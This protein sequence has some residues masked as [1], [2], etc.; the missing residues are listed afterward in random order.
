MGTVSNISKELILEIDQAMYE[1]TSILLHTSGIL[2]VTEIK[3]IQERLIN[4]E[5]SIIQLKEDHTLIPLTHELLSQLQS[6]HS[7]FIKICFKNL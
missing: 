6:I 2:N 3:W 5:I 7:Y 1:I 4:I